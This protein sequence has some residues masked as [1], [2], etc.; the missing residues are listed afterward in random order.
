[1]TALSFSPVP[2]LSIAGMWESLIIAV[3]LPVAL[4]I[5]VRRRLKSA[6]SPVFVGAGTFVVFACV[7]EALV[8]N[9]VLSSALGARL[10][11]TLWAY[12]LYGG[13]M[14]ALFEEFGRLIAMKLFMKNKLTREN[15][16]MYGVG[17]GGIE[18]ILIVGL[19]SVANLGYSAMINSGALEASLAA[20]DAASAE[21]LHAQL[22][23]L[24]T[25]APT[26]FFASGVERISA[27][28]LQIAL[29]YFVYR[30]LAYGKK[31]SFVAALLVHGGVDFVAV[32]LNGRVGIWS[33]ER[34][35]MLM[36]VAFAACAY[37]LY[38]ADAARAQDAAGADVP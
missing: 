17:H 27:I 21:A 13:A 2:A 8:H 25:T 35:I 33:L 38:R 22:S 15:A 16:I 32:L 36:S 9:V 18:A 5:A 24:W 1:M 30:A 19:S 12:A 11:G 10:Q 3:G 31:W 37:H 7:L 23:A 20:L 14:A 6:L 26:L 34:I 29:S 4:C 28:V